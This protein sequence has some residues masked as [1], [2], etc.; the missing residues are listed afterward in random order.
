MHD[1][2]DSYESISSDSLS[3]SED[4]QEEDYDDSGEDN[5]HEGAFGGQLAKRRLRSQWAE[6]RGTSEH[7]SFQYQDRR[8]ME[9]EEFEGG[10]GGGGGGGGMRGRGVMG[11]WENSCYIYERRPMTHRVIHYKY[12]WMDLRHKLS[13]RRI[14]KGGWRVF[15]QLFQSF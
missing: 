2:Y 11:R 12:R 8:N 10:G 1:K 6:Q 5:E 15:A 14:K 3:E 13:R 4:D 9:G 7:P